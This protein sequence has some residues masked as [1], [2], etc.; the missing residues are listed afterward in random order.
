[1]HDQDEVYVIVRGHGLLAQGE[2]ETLA[3]AAFGY[4]MDAEELLGELNAL[5]VGSKGS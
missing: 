4:A 2:D 1:M 5:L 3:E